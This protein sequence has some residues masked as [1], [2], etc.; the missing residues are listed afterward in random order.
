MLIP[1]P[2]SGEPAAEGPKGKLPWSKP[3]IR[4]IEVNFTAAGFN[5]NPGVDEIVDGDGHGTV[6]GPRATY[7]V[8]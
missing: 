3:Q 1:P 5:A 2:Q 4:V 8:S 6:G 7:R